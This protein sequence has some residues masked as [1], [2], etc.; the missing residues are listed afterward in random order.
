MKL[1][2]SVLVKIKHLM[3]G[4]HSRREA[5]HRLILADA[6]RH[7]CRSGRL[8]VIF[9]ANPALI[10]EACKIPRFL[11]D[12]T[13]PAYLAAMKSYRTLTTNYESYKRDNKA[14]CPAALNLQTKLGV[15]EQTIFPHLLDATLL[16]AIQNDQDALLKKMKN[17]GVNFLSP[18]GK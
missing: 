6:S 18:M 14:Q 12:L 7:A 5:R 13:E 16:Y 4:I 15:L 1:G 17:D 2:G 3:M 8:Q 10:E 11:A 9:Y